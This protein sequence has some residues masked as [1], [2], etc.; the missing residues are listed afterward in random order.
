MGDP[1]RNPQASLQARVEKLEHENQKL[2]AR[3]TALQSRPE[4][5]HLHHRR[6][7]WLLVGLL[8]SFGPLFVAPLLLSAP[9]HS[10]AWARRSPPALFGP[11]RAE[12]L[13]PV[14]GGD[15][16]QAFR[17]VALHAGDN[18]D[19]PEGAEARRGGPLERAGAQHGAPLRA[20]PRR[21]QIDRACR[22][23]DSNCGHTIEIDVNDPW[24]ETDERHTTC[25]KGDP[26]CS[27]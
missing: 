23:G 8:A 21:P 3:I 20:E 14:D 17:G 7:S 11:R 12:A 19:A 16:P 1:F 18:P 6:G 25:T 24:V 15:Q 9:S 4:A 5:Q 10:P 13:Q 27:P 26:L 22:P 2:R